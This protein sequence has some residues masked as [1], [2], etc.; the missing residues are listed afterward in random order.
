MQRVESDEQD[1]QTSTSTYSQED[2][3]NQFLSEDDE[4]ISSLG[5]EDLNLAPMKDIF[6]GLFPEE[7]LPEQV[8][9]TKI[10]MNETASS[11]T[12]ETQ[13]KLQWGKYSY[14]IDKK[15]A[16]VIAIKASKVFIVGRCSY[17]T[18]DKRENVYH[19]NSLYKKLRLLSHAF[20]KFYF[21]NLKKG[22]IK[23]VSTEVFLLDNLPYTLSREGENIPVHTFMQAR[24]LIQQEREKRESSNSNQLIRQQLRKAANSKT[25]KPLKRKGEQGQDSRG[26]SKRGKTM[27]N[28]QR[29]EKHLEQKIPQELEIIRH[30]NDTRY[31]L[32]LVTGIITPTDE[33]KGSLT[34]NSACNKL[35]EVGK[36]TRLGKDQCYFVD[37]E[38]ILA[39]PV[40]L[41][42]NAIRIEHDPEYINSKYYAVISESP[43]LVGEQVFL[44]I[45][46]RDRLTKLEES[47]NKKEEQLGQK[48]N[49]EHP[50]TQ[51]KTVCNIHVPQ[52]PRQT[53]T[54]TQTLYYH[55]IPQQPRQLQAPYDHLLSRPGIGLFFLPPPPPPSR[56]VSAP[57]PTRP[58]P[59]ST[60]SDNSFGMPKEPL[61]EFDD[62]ISSLDCEYKGPL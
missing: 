14:Y 44:I 2:Q 56:Q 19:I 28:V 37:D 13:E 30:K 42:K 1:V 58:A 40:I 49:I 18:F 10:E 46:A 15:E 29:K 9:A 24:F 39:R 25:S 3:P 47:Q 21:V 52:Q 59:V 12:T 27:A 62:Y 11:S 17:T 61:F 34:F 33:K 38:M 43:V 50:P 4:F 45:G 6:P 16:I 57:P 55:P 53:Q 48:Q 20:E 54:Q 5:C 26:N 41:G 35:M 22:K 23:H 36:G 8:E 60:S 32:D 51:T 31:S 7:E